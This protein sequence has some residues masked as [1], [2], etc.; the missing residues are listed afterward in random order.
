MTVGSARRFKVAPDL[1]QVSEKCLQT[2]RV[3]QEVAGLVTPFTARV[4]Q[5]ARDRVAADHEAELAAL[6]ADY[7]ARIDALQVEMREKTRVEMRERM[8]RLAG[9]AAGE[10]AGQGGGTH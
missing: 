1:V 2:W 8:M 10:K 3:L 4:E 9:Y 7:E 6:R 5:A